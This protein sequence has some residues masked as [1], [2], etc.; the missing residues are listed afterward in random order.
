[1]V[2]FLRQPIA[3]LLLIAFFIDC[4]STSGAASPLQTPQTQASGTGR[5]IVTVSLEGVRIPAVRISLR[6]ADG[7]VVVGQTTSDNIGQVTFP[8]VAPGR[9]VVLATREGFADTETAPFEVSAGEN[10]QVLVEMRLTFVR[11]SVDVIVPANSPTE[12]LQPVAVSDLLTGAKMDIQP[13][14]G[15]DFQSL[16]T[17]LPSI[18]RGPEGRLRIKGGTP[19]TGALQMS[20]ASLNDPSTGDFDLELPS[21]AV[22]SVEVLSNPFAAEYGRFSTSVT[23]VRTKRGTN[24]WIVKPTNL[25]PG[26]GKGFAFVNKFEP[27]LSISGPLKR[28]RLLFGQYLQYRFLRTPVKSL[29][30]EPQVGVDSFDSFTR[31]D[32]VLS[33]R[34]ALTG[35]VIYFPRKITNATLSTFRPPETT[36]RFWQAGFSAGAVDRLILSSTAVLESTLAARTF[37]IDEKTKGELPMIYAPQGQGGN[38]FNRQERHVRSLQFVEALSVAKNDWAGEHVFK[39]GVDIQYSRFEGD[40][41]SQPVEIVRLDGT[42]AERTTYT[43]P[44]TTPEVT[45]TEVALFVQDRWRVNDR[46]NFELGFRADFDDVVE[47]ANYSPRIGM[48]VS[49]LP[50]GRGILRG[51]FGKFAERTP[52]NVGAFTQ[53]NVQTVTRRAANGTPLGNPVTFAHVVDGEL[54]TPE[55]LV[56][57]VAWDQ[58][59]GRLFFFKT[60]YLHRSGSHAYVVN[61]DP[62]RGVLT[63]GS[64]GDSKYWEIE[65]TGRFLASEYRDISV[66]YVRSHSTRDVNDY[67]QFFGNFRNPIIRA[68][69]N[70]LSPTDVPNRLI[71]RGTFG[72]PGQW[73]FSP[74]YEWRTGF[75][76][77]AVNE[78]Q[79]FVGIRNETG[80]LPSVKTLDF[81]LARPW[82]FKKYRFTAGLK[83]YNAFDTGNERD[84]QNNI[85]SPDYGTF[86]NPIQR[87]IGFV[88]GTTKP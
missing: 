39:G 88:F 38:F 55:S 18:I 40:D 20:S 71:V 52:L 68:N 59:F 86:Y 5:V 51:G 16:L 17:V 53:Y 76:W 41:A 61:P 23:Q 10:E 85:T 42:L 43:P 28:D 80:R 67:D 83:I 44:L 34:H 9:Y 29:P 26:F 45:G 81:T 6:S 32:G 82:H 72:L 21:G 63:L 77:S 58:R 3:R 1:M 56:Q 73:V 35:G 66:S 74:L 69:E 14:A 49:V 7:N 87:S 11:E 12:S 79:D 2:S 54:R 19:T 25:V 70:S 22:E 46:L 8:D 13:L 64:T 37:Q 62:A 4:G 65:T 60:A 31:L 84:V 15:D 57:T 33:S 48:S 36:P 50:E 24:E 27:R 75:P 30:D 78:F 47:R